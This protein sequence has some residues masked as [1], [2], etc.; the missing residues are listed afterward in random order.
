MNYFG[1]SLNSAGHF[2][3]ILSG[4]K[5]KS[6]WDMDYASLPFS[7]EQL[8][9][10]YEAYETEFG[11]VGFYKE[12]GYSIIAIYG[13]CADTRHGTKS[14]FF[15]KEDLTK[16]EMKQKILSIPIANW[17]IDKMPFEVKW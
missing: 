4:E 6:N 3:W 14:V 12:D 9:K 5:M 8:P 1:T 2:F 16:E 13:S 15:I 7:P 17:I 11:T 10:G